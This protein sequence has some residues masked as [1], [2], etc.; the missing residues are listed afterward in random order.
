MKKKKVAPVKKWRNENKRK[1]KKKKAQTLWKLWSLSFR[2]RV[3]WEEKEEKKGRKARAGT[4]HTHQT[5]CTQHTTLRTQHLNHFYFILTLNKTNTKVTEL[6]SLLC[7]V[8]PWRPNSGLRI[9]AS[10]CSQITPSLSLSLFHLLFIFLTHDSWRYLFNSKEI[11]N[12]YL[13]QCFQK[14]VNT[15]FLSLPHHI[16]ECFLNKLLIFSSL[17]IVK[18]NISCYIFSSSPSS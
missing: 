9:A 8:L 5:H 18:Q 3:H 16:L 15:L 2:L 11:S 12:F 10:V 6:V 4:T 17:F 7:D 1:K 14:S 13:K